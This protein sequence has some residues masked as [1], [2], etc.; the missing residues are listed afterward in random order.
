MPM[1]RPVVVGMY[2]AAAASARLQLLRE[3]LRLGVERLHLA[4]IFFRALH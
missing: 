1:T 3:S 4:Q 2:A